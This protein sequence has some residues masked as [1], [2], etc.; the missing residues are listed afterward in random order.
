MPVE[1][2]SQKEGRRVT[3]YVG[4]RLAKENEARLPLPK[5]APDPRYRAWV[6]LD[7]IDLNEGVEE[8][9]TNSTLPSVPSAPSE[10]EVVEK[11]HAVAEQVKRS[12]QVDMLTLAKKFSAKATNPPDYHVLGAKDKAIFLQSGSKADRIIADTAVNRDLLTT[13]F[14]EELGGFENKKL[15]KGMQV[16][17]GYKTSDELLALSKTH[18]YLPKKRPRTKRLFSNLRVA[19]LAKITKPLED[20]DM[21]TPTRFNPNEIYPHAPL[22]FGSPKANT[23]NES[24]GAA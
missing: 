1:V 23:K 19:F 8:E 14:P 3:E 17:R 12:C 7:G 5:V 9:L 20:L 21:I 4:L 10:A 13:S 6:G 16:E 15:A 18:S 11:A 2:K 22:M 24:R